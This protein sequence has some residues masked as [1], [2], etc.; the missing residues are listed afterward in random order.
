[1]THL[2]RPE[3]FDL[4]MVVSLSRILVSAFFLPGPLACPLVWAGLIIFC[5]AVRVIN[6]VPIMEKIETRSQNMPR[7]P[8]LYLTR[9]PSP[10]R[11][12]YL[13]PPCGS[14]RKPR[15]DGG[16][17]G[18]RRRGA[19]LACP[20]SSYTQGPDDSGSLM[21]SGLFMEVCAMT[22]LKIRSIIFG[23]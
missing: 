22:G 12:P 5:H 20:G 17:V 16:S 23:K 9:Y 2:S 7:W 15:T 3:E 11:C 18:D 8:Q 4:L 10:N 6:E 19:G 13:K 21:L 1:M 14:W